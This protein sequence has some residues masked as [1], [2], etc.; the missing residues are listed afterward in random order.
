MSR[1]FIS[2]R[3]L[4]QGSIAAAA[5]SLATIHGVGIEPFKRSGSPRMRLSLAAY[6]FRDDFKASKDGKPARLD[7]FKFIDYCAA[8][9]CEGA[10]LTS[11]Y[12]P[13]PTSN[14]YLARV[15][16]HAHLSGITVS[17]TAVGNVFT[18]AA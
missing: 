8:N 6:S 18:H 3:Q 17:G 16:R 5:A 4:L 2:R 12:F 1:I 11:Y 10:E 9:G 14:D 15:H 13:E 7:M